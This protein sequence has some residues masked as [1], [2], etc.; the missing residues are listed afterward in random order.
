LSPT[1][2]GPYDKQAVFRHFP[3]LPCSK[4]LHSFACFH[5]PIENKLVFIKQAAVFGRE[6]IFPF[7]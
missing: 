6:E 2:V 3:Q 7:S 5:P 4:T 1:V